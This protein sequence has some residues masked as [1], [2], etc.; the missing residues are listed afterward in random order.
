MTII[1][2]FRC[3]RLRCNHNITTTHKPSVRRKILIRRRLLYTLIC[4]YFEAVQTTINTH[5]LSFSLQILSFPF[6]FPNPTLLLIHSRKCLR[7][8]NPHPPLNPYTPSLQLKPPNL[9][10][11]LPPPLLLAVA[12]SVS[13]TPNQP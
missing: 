13:L 10:P 5:S 1:R 6:S 11:F 7:Q 4:R 8:L 9:L 2:R 12:A 3:D